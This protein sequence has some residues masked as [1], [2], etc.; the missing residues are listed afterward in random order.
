VW[1]WEHAFAVMSLMY[2]IQHHFYSRLM[3]SLIFLI[4]SHH[5]N[6]HRQ[7]K[8]SFSHPIKT[9]H[10]F[11]DIRAWV[12]GLVAGANLVLVGEIPLTPTSS[13][14]LQSAII[15]CLITGRYLPP[16]R[17]S[18]IRSLTHPFKVRWALIRHA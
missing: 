15:A 8:L 11:K 9:P 2:S 10:Q 13:L 12:D 5:T 18:I 1:I 16:C 14:H 4:L 3:L 17:I 6:S 7:L